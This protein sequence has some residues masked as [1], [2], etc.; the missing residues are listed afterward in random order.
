MKFT[1]EAKM[2]IVMGV[3]VAVGGGSVAFTHL[4]LPT[5]FR[6]VLPGVLWALYYNHLHTSCQSVTIGRSAMSVV[7]QQ[8]ISD[9]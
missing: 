1:S 4:T 9:K 6:V 7:A 3:I 2:L 5:N 8:P